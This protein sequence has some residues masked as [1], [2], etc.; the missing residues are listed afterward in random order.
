MNEILLADCVL[1]EKYCN[2]NCKYCFLGNDFIIKIPPSKT[3]FYIRNLK[4]IIEE[5]KDTRVSAIKLSGGEIFLLPKLVDTLKY[6]PAFDKIQLLTNGTLLNESIIKEIKKIT[7]LGLQITLDGID[8]ESNRYRFPNV[9]I[10]ERVIGNLEKII[11]NGIPLEINLCL[12][13]YNVNRLKNFLDFLLSL[14]SN[15]VMLYPIPVRESEYKF[16]IFKSQLIYIEEIMLNYKQ[17]QSVLPPYAYLEALYHMLYFG[18]K[19]KGWRCYIPDTVV[20]IQGNGDIRLC[21][22]SGSKDIYGNLFTESLEERI[23]RNKKEA[24]YFF[25][26]NHCRV[27][28]QCKD[29]F[30]HYEVINLFIDNKISS[31][32]IGRI[33]LFQCKQILDKLILLKKIVYESEAKGKV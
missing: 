12:T 6:I 30:T 10:F 29:C 13:R 22:E 7:N 2:L 1:Y 26:K 33:W 21:S 19:P 28:P 8:Y 15:C 24:N 11:K 9:Q 32:D 25:M 27:A 16:G 17:Y 14:D 31:Y 20:G 18:C 23:T 5:V 3:E 4:K